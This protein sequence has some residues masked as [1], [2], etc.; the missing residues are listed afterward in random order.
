MFETTLVSSTLC[1][2]Q[3]MGCCL[4]TEIRKNSKV[5]NAH[6]S[7]LALRSAS[8]QFRKG[9]LNNRSYKNNMPANLLTTSWFLIMIFLRKSH[10]SVSNAS[11]FFITPSR[12]F[13]LVCT[14]SLSCGKTI[15]WL[16]KY[17]LDNGKF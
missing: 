7:Q 12:L 8:L 13:L 15:R 2:S 14:F 5:C 3:T 16:L 11:S 6:T 17:N 9:N 10:R 1:I 4:Y